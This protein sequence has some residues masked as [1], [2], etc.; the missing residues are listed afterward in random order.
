MTRA[1]QQAAARRLWETLLTLACVV[2]P[3]RPPSDDRRPFQAAKRY[4]VVKPTRLC[5]PA[6][7][8]DEPVK[9]SDAH[10]MCYQLKLAKTDPRQAKHTRRI[11]VRVA[12]QLV[13]E[14]VDTVKEE[15]LCV[16]STMSALS[17]T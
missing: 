6:E 1:R 10:L 15:E 9:R 13:R 2:V 3:E 8:N 5:T 4:A 11:G 14:R 17:P 7:K 16:P 12:N